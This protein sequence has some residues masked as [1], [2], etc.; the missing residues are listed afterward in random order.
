MQ[1]GFGFRSS[2]V[3]YADGEQQWLAYVP[4]RAAAVGRG[5]GGRGIESRAAVC[6]LRCGVSIVQIGG[7]GDN[8]RGWWCS[9]M[10]V[11]LGEVAGA[12]PVLD[13]R[14]PGVVVTRP[15]TVDIRA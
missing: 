14:L 9:G 3:R 7:G 15:D 4:A 1:V 8:L 5:R 2:G 6:E 10:G 13:G 11:R 12:S